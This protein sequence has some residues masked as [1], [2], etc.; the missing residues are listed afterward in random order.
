MKQQQRRTPSRFQSTVVLLLLFTALASLPVQAQMWNGKDTLYGNEWIDFSQKYYKLQVAEDGIYRLNQNLLAAAGFPTGTVNGDQLRLYRNGREVPLFV[1]SNGLL[2]NSDF[3]EFYGEKNRDE[4]DR[5]LFENGLEEN[6]NTRYSLFNDTS[7]YYLTWGGSS[8]QKQRYTLINNDLSNLPPKQ[9]AVWSVREKVFTE[10]H[11]KR[12]LTDEIYFSWFDGEGFASVAN[13]SNTFTLDC[14]KAAWGNGQPELW[15]RYAC[16]LGQHRQ[17]IVVN[18]SVYI[19]DAFQLWKV[20]E[21]KIPVKWTA[22]TS[23]FKA[24]I[25][26]AIGGNDRNVVAFGRLRYPQKPEYDNVPSLFFELDAS[27][28][29]AQYLEIQGFDAGSGR[30]VVYDLTMRQRLEGIMENN[31]LKIKLPASPTTRQIV[32]ANVAKAVKTI[33]NLF[34]VQFQDFSAASGDYLIITHPRLE[35]PLNGVN[36]VDA[37]ADY[38][39][40][41]AGGNHKVV[42]ADI[43]Q[44]QEQFGYGIRFHPVALRN[45][46]HYAKKKWPALKHTFII[47][48]G[49]DYSEFRDPLRQAQLGDSLF[50]IPTFST[51]AA[52]VPFTMSGARLSNPITTIGRLAVT[53]PA[54]I[55]DYLQKVKTHELAVDNADLSIDGRAWMKRVIHNSGG[56]SKES[57]AIR[58]YMQNMT[59]ILVNNQFGADVHT[60]Y[61]TS[62]DPI[63]LS[64]YEQMLDLLNSGVSIWT[65]FGH[66]SPFAVDFDIGQPAEY[67]NQGRYPLMLIMGCFS[68]LCTFPQQGIGEQF[69]LAP[70]RGAIAYVASVNYSFVHALHAYAAK[71]Y[72]LIGGKDYYN[73]IGEA[74]QH[75]IV[76]LK[77][78]FDQALVA[79]LHQNFLQGD[80]AIRLHPLPGA[81]YVIDNQ[82]VKFEPNPIS[83]ESGKFKLQ[84]DVVNIGSHPGGKM[85]IKITQQLPDNNSLVRIVDTIPVPPNR[86][87]LTYEIPTSGSQI[88][89]NRFL[90]SAD[91]YNQIAE[92]PTAAEL[93]ND[94]T[95]NGEKGIPVY[96]YADD[97]QPVHPQD[98]G[99]IKEEKVVLRAS[100]LNTSA[101]LQR[102]IFEID[103]IESFNSPFKKTTALQQKGGLLEWEPPLNLKD[104]TVYYWRVARDSLVGGQLVWRSHSFIRLAQVPIAGGWNQSHFGQFRNNLFSSVLANDITRKMEFTS[105][106]S[107]VIL[108]VAYRGVERYPGFQNAYYEG[109]FGDFGFGFHETNDGVV[110]AMGDPLTGRFVKNPKNGPY[111]HQPSEQLIF[112]RFVT[113]DSLERVKLMYFLE[114]EIPDD[115]YVALM[116]FGTPWDPISYAPQDW[117]KDSVTNGKNLF[118]LIEKYG[119][120]KV[121]QLTKFTGAPHPYG[122]VFQ[123]NNTDFKPVD[124]IVYNADS[125][126]TLRASFKAKWTAGQFETPIIGPV[127]NWKSLHW[128]TEPFDDPVKE[129]VELSVLGLRDDKPD[130]VLMTLK[131]TFDVDLSGIPAQKFP[132]LKFRYETR[133]TARRTLTQ[134]VYLRILYDD[135]PEGALHPKSNFSFYRDTLERGETLR[136]TVAY[137]N[138][139]SSGMD[140]ILVRYRIEGDNNKGI[141]TLKR[142]QKLGINDSLVLDYQES[143]KN[144]SGTQ[145]LLVEV[146]PDNDQ[147]ERHHFNNVMV[148]D[149]YVLNDRRNPLLDVT[150]D[151]LHIL[152]GDLVSPQPEVFVVLK[153][154]NRYL[155]IVDSSSL[156]LVLTLPDGQ[157]QNLWFSD[158]ALRFFPAEPSQLPKNNSARVEWRPKLTQDG[159]Y[160]L[161]VDGQDASGN[162]SANLDWSVTFKVVTKSSL[163]NILN[164]PNPFSSSTCFVYTLTGAAPPAHFKVQIMTVSGRVVREITENEFGPLRPGT[165]RSNFCWD[166]RDEYGDQLANGVYLYRIIAKKQDGSDFDL[167]EN[168]SVDGFFKNGFGK[169]VIMR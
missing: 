21:H 90:I 149:F 154:D 152:D 66:S 77:G 106:A 76:D 3:I 29:D 102:Y 155:P 132:Q 144:I 105:N 39:R 12:R 131:N 163:S 16:G 108:N 17:E 166:G 158:P 148:R 15:V 129:V 110:L 109:F 164:Y 140:S 71:Y 61:K 117:A 43:N 111:N 120:K 22:Q 157:R 124:T 20:N 45:F 128:K 57:A 59:N 87:T 151:G 23:A 123:K 99:I 150:F 168:Q 48:K 145:R 67:N 13:T 119:G 6:L 91:I 153:D 74:L 49:P 25:R 92:K 34:P 30:P 115:Y 147:P 28:N 100:T 118:Q 130:S 137:V 78:T 146:N 160:R 88:G 103:T 83:L 46:L 113:R 26:S 10:Q 167:F 73:S 96:F 63:Q 139:S 89:F 41:S 37:Y 2:G 127:T 32:V 101:N 165:H 65:I 72:D 86:S 95:T 156:R 143:T 27:P 55:R 136:A 24:V 75:S 126:V 69:V 138:I 64:S 35:R 104:S 159:T 19:T 98:Y 81:D 79:I 141:E 94:L 56:T 54:Q 97:I 38:R 114:N 31:I 60:F 40:S 133:D 142:Y 121:R 135:I 162:A 134:P 33:T 5:F 85:S 44:I 116:A 84:F 112:F 9:N 7:A 62:D 107:N 8:G 58:D 80:P 42:I 50:L 70:D 161:S 47:G 169:M 11:S 122:L 68:G 36:Y 14:P 125:L 93:N 1:S 18:D 51:P 4:V 52:D 82:S 53:N